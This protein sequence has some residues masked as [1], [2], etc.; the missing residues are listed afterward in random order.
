MNSV[1]RHFL[2]IL[3]DGYRAVR[4]KKNSLWLPPFL[5]AVANGEMSGKSQDLM[6]LYHGAQS[7]SKKKT[8]SVLA[9]NY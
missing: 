6:A 7:S 3:I 9:K 8:L 1:Y 2:T 4:L 5:M